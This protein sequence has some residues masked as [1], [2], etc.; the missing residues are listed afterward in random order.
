MRFSNKFKI[1]LVVF[2]LLVICFSYYFYQIFFTPNV[3]SVEKHTKKEFTDTVLYIPTGATIQTVRD[4]LDKKEF[5]QD[6]ASFYFLT[7]LMGYNENVKPGRYVLK[8]RSTNVEV[9]K[10]LK[11]G[12]QDPIKLTFNNVRLKKDLAEKIGKYLEPSPKDIEAKLNDSA[13]AAK[14]GF[15]TTTIISMFIPD[16]YEFYWNT[17]VEKFFSK[18]NDQYKKFWDEERLNKAKSLGLTP[19]QVSILASIVQAE[20][21]YAPEKARIAG[22][23]LNRL[24]TNMPLQADPTLVFAAKCFDAQRVYNVHKDIESPY[25]TY[26]YTGLPPGPINLPSKNSLDAVLNAENHKYYYFCASELFNGSHNFAEDYNEHL[27]NA[28]KYTKALNDRDIK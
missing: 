4:S 18:M 5:I 28:R 22:V 17:S 14:Y 26:K 3:L 15:D 1:F 13:Y 21:Q 16:T 27:N 24:R 25:N 19:I 2:G 10:K 9:I 20:S 7:R 11:R 8:K 6:R 12:E 23:Y